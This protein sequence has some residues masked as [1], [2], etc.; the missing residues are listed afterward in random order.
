MGMEKDEHIFMADGR[1][2]WDNHNGVSSNSWKYI[3]NMI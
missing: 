2:Y 3:Y 1:T